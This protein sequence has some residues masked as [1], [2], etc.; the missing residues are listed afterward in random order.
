MP[1]DEGTDTDTL[2]LPLPKTRR[3]S[4]AFQ[5]SSW[6][7]A[8]EFKPP[9]QQ[10]SLRHRRNG[11]H[12]KGKKYDKHPHQ[13]HGQEGGMGMMMMEEEEEDDDEQEKK[14]MKKNKREERKRGG[15]H[16]NPKIR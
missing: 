12:N 5:S 16:M 11:K 6:R 4:I 2:P 8:W 3:A 13:Y 14:K 1:N 7:D 15:D 10:E 9:N